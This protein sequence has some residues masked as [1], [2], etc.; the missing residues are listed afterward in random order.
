MLLFKAP[1]FFFLVVLPI[2]WGD[3]EVSIIVEMPILSNFWFYVNLSLGMSSVFL[4]FIG[5]MATFHTF[6][7]CSPDSKVLY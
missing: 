1:N 5:L 2:S 7:R 6:L 3:V 4:E